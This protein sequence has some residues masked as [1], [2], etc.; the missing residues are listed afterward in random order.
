ATYQGKPS[1]LWPW[2][3]PATRGSVSKSSIWGANRVEAQMRLRPGGG[4]G[5]IIRLFDA[6]AHRTAD[7]AL[8]LRSN[9]FIFP[10]LGEHLTRHVSLVRPHEPVPAS[11]EWLVLAPGVRVGTCRGAWQTELA[12]HDKW[13]IERRI[14]R[15]SC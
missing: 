12:T 9:D 4:E 11:T 3:S 8:A 5:S 2:R 1:G 14:G 13:R 15:D 7:V 10:C 6:K